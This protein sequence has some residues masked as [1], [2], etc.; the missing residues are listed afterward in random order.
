[1][2]N[3]NMAD[4]I[5]PPSWLFL[6]INYHF[7]NSCS[8]VKSFHFFQKPPRKSLL[9]EPVTHSSQTTPR[10]I[11]PDSSEAQLDIEHSPT[12]KYKKNTENP[13]LVGQMIEIFL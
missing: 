12:R 10:H 1:M 8:K 2:P 6:L 11:Q 4:L 5:K 13:L 3:K 7:V 9:P